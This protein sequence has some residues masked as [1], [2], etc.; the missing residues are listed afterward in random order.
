M[1][2]L[3]LSIFHWPYLPNIY[4]IFRESSS[5][6]TKVR[7]PTFICEDP[8]CFCVLWSQNLNFCLQISE[9]IPEFW[10]KNLKCS[11]WWFISVDFLFSLLLFVLCAGLCWVRSKVCRVFLSVLVAQSGSRSGWRFVRRRDRSR[12]RE[13]R[14]RPG[15]RASGQRQ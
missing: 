9:S 1:E 14:G 2:F 10:L 8:N 15:E 7:L 13:S 6:E 5:L 3:V 11:V 4:L 12:Q